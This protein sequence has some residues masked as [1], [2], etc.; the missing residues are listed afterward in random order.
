MGLPSP[1]VISHKDLP[2]KKKDFKMYD[3]ILYGDGDRPAP[4]FD[5]EMD[6]FMPMLTDYLKSEGLSVQAMLICLIPCM[7]STMCIH[8]A[9]HTRKLLRRSLRCTS[10]SQPAKVMIMSGMSSITGQR[11]LA[12]GTRSQT[13]GPCT[14]IYFV[15]LDCF[16][17]LG[18]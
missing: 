12:N 15:V 5:S 17:C 6:K 8:P 16:C 1:K 18:S 11:N 14:F 13:L 4:A 10:G 9:L 7:K 3:A 2:T